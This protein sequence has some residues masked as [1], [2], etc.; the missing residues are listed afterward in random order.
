MRVYTAIVILTILMEGKKMTMYLKDQIRELSQL[1]LNAQK[2]KG[3]N[4]SNP[5]HT[6]AGMNAQDELDNAMLLL[7]EDL[8]TLR[9]NLIGEESRIQSNLWQVNCYLQDAVKQNNKN[10]NSHVAKWENAKRGGK[11]A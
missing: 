9:K 1:I 2:I 10:M 11:D 8:Q 5:I 4:K 7:I 6:T 3:D